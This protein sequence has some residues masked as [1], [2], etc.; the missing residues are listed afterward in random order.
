MSS[1][2][3]TA[4]KKNAEGHRRTTNATYI[5]AALTISLNALLEPRHPSLQMQRVSDNPLLMMEE[6]LFHSSP[7]HYLQ[8]TH[9]SHIEK[10][11]VVSLSTLLKLLILAVRLV[12]RSQV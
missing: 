4:D 3:A 2:E 12:T 5:T 1:N 6:Q 8:N 10:E 11:Q 9:H 7:A